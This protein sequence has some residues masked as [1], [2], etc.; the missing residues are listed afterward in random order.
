MFMYIVT[1]DEKKDNQ[2][3]EYC[4]SKQASITGRSLSIVSPWL[5]LKNKLDLFGI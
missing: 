3:I 2:A 1:N 4:R 5:Q